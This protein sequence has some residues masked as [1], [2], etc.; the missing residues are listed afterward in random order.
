MSRNIRLAGEFGY[1]ILEVIMLFECGDIVE[2][3]GSR[4][5][6]VDVYPSRPANPYIVIKENGRGATYKL[7]HGCK[8]VGHISPDHPVLNLMARRDISSLKPFTKKL[9]WS[10]LAGDGAA[11]DTIL[12]LLS[13]PQ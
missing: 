7:G 8:K 6:I 11:A 3:F 5:V 10:A 4:Y 9:L 2:A 1:L 12:G 13:Q